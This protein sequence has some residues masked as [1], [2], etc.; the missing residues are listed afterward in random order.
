M[1]L[2]HRYYDPNTGR[3]VTRDP[4]GYKGGINLYGFV[5]NNPVNRSDPSGFDPDDPTGL[6]ADTSG[7]WGYK[8]GHPA[9]QNGTYEA[10]RAN[11]MRRSAVDVFFGAL[12][13]VVSPEGKIIDEAV[14]GFQAWKIARDLKRSQM[15]A[16][17]RAAWEPRMA[18]RA[19]APLKPAQILANRATALG[20][21]RRFAPKIWS[22]GQDVFFNGN[23]YISRDHTAHNAM[24]GWKMFDKKGE[25]LGT[26]DAN[27]NP[28]KE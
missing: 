6:P 7:H 18:A 28:I 13:A 17:G 10:R 21:P 26:F 3:F 11:A 15:Q 25:R 16:A 14:E 23:N 1:L 2:T 22:H 20:F 24:D 12:I 27:L 4:I 5:G 9:M 19:V 8:T